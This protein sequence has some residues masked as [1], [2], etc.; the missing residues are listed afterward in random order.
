MNFYPYLKKILFSLEPET[1]HDLIKG[2]GRLTPKVV[3]KKLTRA[4]NPVLKT[5][6][7]GVAINS[8]IGLAAG[9]DKNAEMIDW[10]GVLGFGFV[11]IG[12]VTAKATKGNA[13]PR[14]FRLPED[15]S[16]INRM[17]LPNWGAKAVAHQLMH[18]KSPM[19]LGINL[20]K[21]PDIGKTPATKRNGVEDF[22]ESFNYLKSFGAYLVLNLSCPNT[23][24]G[25]TFEDPAI[26]VEL[27]QA[28]AQARAREKI[29]KPVFV[30]LSPEMN[31][32]RVKKMVE[33]ACAYQFDGFVV[34]NTTQNRSS[35]S[36]PAKR[37]ELIGRGGVSGGALTQ[38][39]N[40]QLRQVSQIIGNDKTLIGVGGVM[41]AEDLLMKLALGAQFI[42]VYT[43]LIYQGPLFVHDLNTRL[44]SFCRKVG[45]KHYRELVG[46]MKVVEAGL[47]N[48]V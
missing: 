1:A 26:F 25:K 15:E 8:P 33:L 48:K 12:S 29:R 31:E 19:P 27:A 13:R 23:D 39:A 9:F 16:L 24:D 45:V 22:L 20:A 2:I 28:I 30:K 44:A 4:A 47:K 34:S 14:I 37:L 11:E 43:G 35:L 46:Q 32:S 5:Y 40:R 17:G 18:Q 41:S 7:G 10:L 42:Q 36:T 6:L 38:L 21:T 3:F